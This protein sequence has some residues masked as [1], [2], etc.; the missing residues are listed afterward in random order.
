MYDLLK[1]LYYNELEFLQ[2]KYPF[3]DPCTAVERQILSQLK[4]LDCE[5]AELL[6]PQICTLVQEQ[7]A[8]AFRSGARFG[9]QLITQFME[10]V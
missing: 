6:K 9:A 7:T 4:M 10:E 1:A 2:N 3:A 5:T 8:D